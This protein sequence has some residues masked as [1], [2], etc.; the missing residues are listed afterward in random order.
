MTIRLLT[1]GALCG[2]G[3]FCASSGLVSAQNAGGRVD[4]GAFEWGKKRE[5]IRDGGRGQRGRFNGDFDR[6]GRRT[7]VVRPGGQVDP[8]PIRPRIFLEGN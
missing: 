2:L 3:F 6:D 4:I 7:K 5:A 1:V 8:R